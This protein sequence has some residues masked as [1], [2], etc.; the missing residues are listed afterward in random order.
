MS[1][2]ENN[3]QE[4]KT[5]NL[6]DQAS[7][8]EA[9]PMFSR[10]VVRE[11][12]LSEQTSNLWCSK[13]FIKP[14]IGCGAVS[15]CIL[16]ALFASPT[17]PQPNQSTPTSGAVVA[18]DSTPGELVETAVATSKTS[19]EEISIYL[20]DEELSGEMLLAFVENPDL[21]SDEEISYLMGF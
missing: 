10:N 5:W 17:L 21:L 3:N 6:L 19:I 18:Q 9:S 13:L 7:K 8:Q 11:I 20:G 1:T 4:S 2:S 12:R 14:L 15:T 16:F